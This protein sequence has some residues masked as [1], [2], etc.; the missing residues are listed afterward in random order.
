MVYRWQGQTIAVIFDSRGGHG[1]VP[2]GVPE[3]SPPAIPITSEE[4]TAIEH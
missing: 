3:E 4:G 2:P 1:P